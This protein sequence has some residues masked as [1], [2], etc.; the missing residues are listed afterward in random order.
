M[1]LTAVAFTVVLAA[2]RGRWLTAVEVALLAALGLLVAPLAAFGAYFGAWHAVRHV[3]RLLEE[4]PRNTDDLQ[5]G[6]LARP[7]GRFALAAALPTA[8]A[9]GT[10]LLLWSLADGWRG[11]VTANLSLLA[12]LT[13]PHVVVVTWWD[14]H[15]RTGR[16]VGAHDHGGHQLGGLHGRGRGHA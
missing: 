3:A 11:F 5:G 12:G 1:V 8:V 9:L 13:V 7:L 4:D 14:R 16:D 10:V 2:G 6:H 15:Q